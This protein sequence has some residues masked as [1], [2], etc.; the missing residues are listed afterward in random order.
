MNFF[1]S[2]RKFI[3]LL[4]YLRAYFTATCDLPGILNIAFQKTIKPLIRISYIYPLFINQLT[5]S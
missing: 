4:I 2:T 3:V 5:F 1:E